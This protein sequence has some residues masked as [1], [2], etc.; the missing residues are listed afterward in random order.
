MRRRTL[1]TVKFM[2]RF[3][4]Q[5]FLST[6]QLLSLSAFEGGQMISS[7]WHGHKWEVCVNFIIRVEGEITRIGVT[8]SFITKFSQN[9]CFFVLCICK[10]TFWDIIIFAQFYFFLSCTQLFSVWTMMS[11][12]FLAQSCIIFLS[13][14][15]YLSMISEGLRGSWL[16][17]HRDARC[18]WEHPL[19]T[20]TS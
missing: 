16:K 7:K 15:C 3:H 1:M 9:S 4:N 20:E 19:N 13:L 5:Q 17:G 2:D 8:V 14:I 18:C 6:L 12:H 11:F 10:N